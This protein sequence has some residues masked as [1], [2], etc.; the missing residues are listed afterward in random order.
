MLHNLLFSKRML[1]FFLLRTCLKLILSVLTFK[2]FLL[3]FSSLSVVAKCQSV[4]TKL[5]GKFGNATACILVFFWP[6]NLLFYFFFLVA[7][8]NILNRIYVLNE[9]ILFILSLRAQTLSRHGSNKRIKQL[10]L[11]DLFLRAVRI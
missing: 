6:Y 8:H 10:L 3:N 11:M 2:L 9:F 4:A 1:E 7:I 5:T